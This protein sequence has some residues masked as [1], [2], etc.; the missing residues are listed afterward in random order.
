MFWHVTGCIRLIGD[1]SLVLH[2]RALQSPVFF[3]PI[4]NHELK[5]LS[6]RQSRK[7]KPVLNEKDDK[8]LKLENVSGQISE[9]LLYYILC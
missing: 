8:E 2:I 6:L 3:K 9:N 5:E 1:Q 4:P 7:R